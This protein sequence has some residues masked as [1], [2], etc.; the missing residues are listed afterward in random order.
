MLITFCHIANASDTPGVLTHRVFL[1][2]CEAGQRQP[3]C[4]RYPD[5]RVDA[6]AAKGPKKGGLPGLP[7]FRQGW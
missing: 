5:D 7:W 3:W 4:V 2:A 1:D 6:R